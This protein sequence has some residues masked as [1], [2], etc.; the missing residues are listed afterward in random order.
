[1]LAGNR[2]YGRERVFEISGDM[3]SREYRDFGGD[4][5]TIDFLNTGGHGIR[6]DGSTSQ[7]PGAR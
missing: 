5:E 2:N 3:P 7:E 4:A 1:M 6:K